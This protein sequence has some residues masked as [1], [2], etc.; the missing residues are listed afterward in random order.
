[1]REEP[2]SSQQPACGIPSL[3][4]LTPVSAVLLFKHRRPPPPA[5]YPAPKP[6]SR[7]FRVWTQ[8]PCLPLAKGSVATQGLHGAACPF[9]VDTSLVACGIIIIQHSKAQTLSGALEE[10]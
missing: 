7:E 10:F 6:A 1:M 9:R 5:Q 4:T 3:L 8:P 2:I